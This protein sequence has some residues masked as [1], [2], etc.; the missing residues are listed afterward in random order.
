MSE[1]CRLRIRP[2][3]GALGA[4]IDGV[5]LAASLDDAIV[6]EIRQALLDHLVVFF[7]DQ[8]LSPARLVT[9][10][11]RFGDL[12]HYPFI[13]GLPDQ[14]EVI[15]VLKLEHERWNFGGIWHSDTTYLTEPP[16]GSMLYA[17]EVPAVG[18]D[19]L[20]ANTHLAYDALSEGMKRMLADL[21][22]ISS[23]A[24]ADVTRTREDRIASNPATQARSVFEA[25]HPVV[26]THPE[27]GR[28]GL[29]VNIG[30]TTRLDGTTEA[31]SAPLLDFLFQHQVRPEFTC[32]F[33]WRQGSLAFWDNRSALH[34]PINDYHGNRR[35]MHRVTIA[36]DRPR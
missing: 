21:K 4:E 36:G 13:R 8:S 32:R 14:P 17:L 2:I 22:G 29:Y 15:E 5:D 12:G 7:N 30:H 28:K 27:S 20:F 16:L 34:N 31:E 24:K 9:F 11:R 3:D 35:R 1:L 19:T 18:G 6:A 26:R 33:C 10:A 25:A 23:S